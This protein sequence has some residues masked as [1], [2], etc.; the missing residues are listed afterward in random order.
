MDKSEMISSAF[1]TATLAWSIYYLL[2]FFGFE[3]FADIM[4]I[5]VF[6]WIVV[7]FSSLP[8]CGAIW[9]VQHVRIK[10]TII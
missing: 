9:C 10:I 1:G 6:I 5:P 2:S 4:L 8:I 7:A 3:W